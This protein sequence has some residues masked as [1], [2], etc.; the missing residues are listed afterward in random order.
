MTRYIFT[1][2]LIGGIMIAAL[3][4]LTIAAGAHGGSFG[5][6]FG[7]L[8]MFVALSMIFVGVKRYRDVALGG[9]IR[10]WQA[11]GCGAGIAVVASCCYVIGWEIYLA[12]TDYRF[13][14]DYAAQSLAAEQAAGA[15]AA[16]LSA[17]RSELDAM[18]IYYN[19][20]LL[21]LG[22]TFSEIAPVG[23]VIALVSAALLRNDRFLPARAT[24]RA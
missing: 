18:A 17:L 21:R 11:L 19:N 2:G 6:A 14:A 8:L 22:I 9:T 4:T 24:P 20:P 10:F 15:S 1:Y 3:A 5:V 16:E 12:A 7:F 23:I 13:M